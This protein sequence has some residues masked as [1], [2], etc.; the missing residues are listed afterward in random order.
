MEREQ[1]KL[2]P[3]LIKVTKKESYVIIFLFTSD[4]SE[5]IRQGYKYGKRHKGEGKLKYAEQKAVP[6]T[7]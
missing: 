1:R 4:S 6:E 2:F 3:L 7:D 5:R